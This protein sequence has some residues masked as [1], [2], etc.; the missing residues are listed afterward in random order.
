MN[1]QRRSVLLREEDSAAAAANTITMLQ[2]QNKAATN[3]S[4]LA[5]SKSVLDWFEFAS[6][7]V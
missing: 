7:L 1:A 5:N 3:V 6:S 2:R 4:L